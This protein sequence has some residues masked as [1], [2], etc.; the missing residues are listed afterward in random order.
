MK[1]DDNC[2]TIV[3]KTPQALEKT[4]GR[5]WRQDG[6]WLIKDQNSGISRQRLGDLQRLERLNGQ[7]SDADTYADVEP[8]VPQLFRPSAFYP[9][10]PIERS[11]R[12]KAAKFQRLGNG[13]R[14]R[15]TETL[16]DHLHAPLPSLPYVAQCRLQTLYPD[17][18]TVRTDKPG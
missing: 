16:V 1:D 4:G 14:R 5:G 12:P 17:S 13:E 15:E 8:S 18:A 10:T 7:I 2:H 3:A 9:G 6:R 11:E